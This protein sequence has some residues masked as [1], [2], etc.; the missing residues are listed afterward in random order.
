MLK[1][2]TRALLAVLSLAAWAPLAQ[3]QPLSTAFTFQ[4]EMRTNGLVISG[5][6]DM[7]FRLYDA[8][9]G[10]STR[11]SARLLRPSSKSGEGLVASVAVC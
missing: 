5:R 2:S 1:L 6:Y 3:A 10:D 7:R 9:P 4:G 11:V 8:P